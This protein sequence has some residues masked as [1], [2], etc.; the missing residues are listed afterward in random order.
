MKSHGVTIQM[1]SLQQYFHKILFIWQVVLTSDSVDPVVLPFKRNLFSRTFTWYYLFFG[2]LT[3]EIWNCYMLTLSHFWKWNSKLGR[4]ED[5]RNVQTKKWIPKKRKHVDILSYRIS[6]TAS[7]KWFLC[8]WWSSR[9]KC[10]AVG[11]GSLL[12]SS[13]MS[14][15]P[16][17]LASIRSKISKTLI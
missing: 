7:L 11:L 5:T 13:K 16:V 6:P 12:S 3:K 14:I 10:S 1:N 4:I 9:V 15:I 2:N 17:F 8:F